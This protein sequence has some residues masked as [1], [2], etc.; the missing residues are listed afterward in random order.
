[1]Y[2]TGKQDAHR[3]LSTHSG[4][5]GNHPRS[6]PSV[7]RAPSTNQIPAESATAH[8]LHLQKAAITAI[9]LAPLASWEAHAAQRATMQE[10]S[11]PRAKRR[12]WG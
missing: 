6:A 7:S 10:R 4:R 1:M 2:P 5:I 11:G 3:R 12:G 9:P 8:A